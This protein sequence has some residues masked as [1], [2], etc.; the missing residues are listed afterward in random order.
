[1]FIF[2]TTMQINIQDQSYVIEKS[3][4]NLILPMLSKDVKIIDYSN[5]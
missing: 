4:W 3:D 1:M 5:N 2:A